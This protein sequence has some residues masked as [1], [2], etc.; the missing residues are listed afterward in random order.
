MRHDHRA[1]F[2]K[3]DGEPWCIDHE[4]PLEKCL[5]ALLAETR[6]LAFRDR[7]RETARGLLIHTGIPVADAVRDA[8]VLERLVEEAVP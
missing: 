2:E 7:V 5:E 6:L 8:I 3:R 1:N 4:Q